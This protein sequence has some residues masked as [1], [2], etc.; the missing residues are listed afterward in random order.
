VGRE[1]PQVMPF[2]DQIDIPRTAAALAALLIT[3]DGQIHPDE[4]AIAISLGRSMFL[5]FCPL[6]FETMLNGVDD[7]PKARELA[8]QVSPLLD[9]D[10]KVLIMEYLVA[11]AVADD[12]LVDAEQTTLSEIA[13]ALGTDMPSQLPNRV[14]GEQGAG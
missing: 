14:E 13:Q 6:V 9:T 7:L 1:V 12:R 8:D 5:D 10:G 11:L 3:A 2:H 4:K